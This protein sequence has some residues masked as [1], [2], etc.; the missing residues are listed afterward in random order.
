[1]KRLLV[2]GA[3][4]FLGWNVCLA[5]C[6]TWRVTGTVLTHPLQIP[7]CETV[8]VDLTDYAAVKAVFARV[9]PDAVIHAAAMKNPNDCQL[10]PVL[11]RRMNVEVTAML[12]GLC[13]DRNIP[14]L[15]TS[16]DLVFD[17]L[18]APYA[19]TAAVCPIS[20]Y[21]EQKV[22][23]E[24]EVHRRC[25]RGLVCRMPLM[26]GAGSPV[27]GS[28]SRG[29]VESL[30]TG[31]PVKLFTDEYRTPV[32][33]I[34]AAAGL[35]LALEQGPGTL[36]L[37]GR[38][39]I[40]RWEFGRL[41]AEVCLLSPASLVPVLQ[42]DV[43]LAAPRPPDVSLDSTRAFALGYQPAALRDQCRSALE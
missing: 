43:A 2:T 23:A 29:L 28:F 5:A 7:G 3:S 21:G 14:C 33:G 6:K 31:R 4:G 32:D 1:M 22:Q 10:E 12:A 38:E 37:G 17:G 25:A 24:E 16:S 11:S 35:M 15:F 34:T 20:A 41:L 30:R 39:R 8:R 36:H 9:G 26:F 13:E 40:S 42:K 19:E 27:A 18:Q